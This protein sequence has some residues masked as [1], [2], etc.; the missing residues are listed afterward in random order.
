MLDL[1]FD[2]STEMVLRSRDRLDHGAFRNKPRLQCLLDNFAS[3]IRD[4]DAWPLS[5]LGAELQEDTQVALL[6][7]GAY[8]GNHLQDVRHV[9]PHE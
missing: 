5:Q 3:L 9:R 6:A 1:D 2:R 8:E 7:H 4:Q